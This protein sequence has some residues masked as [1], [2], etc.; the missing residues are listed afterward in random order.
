MGH[1]KN[2]GGPRADRYKWG[3]TGWVTG[4][5]IPRSGLIARLLT[6]RGPP[7]HHVLEILVTF[8]GRVNLTNSKVVK[9]GVLTTIQLHC[10]YVLVHLFPTINYTGFY[11][12]QVVFL[13]DFWLPSTVCVG[14]T[15]EAKSKALL[16]QK[17]HSKWAPTTSST[18]KWASNFTCMG[19]FHPSYPFII[20]IYLY[21]Y[22]FSSNKIRGEISPQL[23][24]H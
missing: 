24:A 3:E 23:G 19:L 10:T 16:S 20:M 1:G 11:T 8:L 4:L 13:P 5:I 7:C 6:G 2:R 17:A 9:G 14:F 18:C 21:I 15:P 22:I 12:F